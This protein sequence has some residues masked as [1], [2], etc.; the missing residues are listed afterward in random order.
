MSCLVLEGVDNLQFKDEQDENIVYDRD[1]KVQ[2]LVTGICGSDVHYWKKGS[3]GEFIV[4]SPLILGHESAGRVVEVGEHVKDVKIGDLVALEPSKPC[5]HCFDCKRGKYNLCPFMQFAATPPFHG[6]LRKYYVLP[7]DFCYKLPPELSVEEGALMEP[8]SVA[9]HMVKEASISFGHS[10]VIFGAGPIGLLCSAVARAYGASIVVVVDI[11]KE[12]LKFA[13]SYAAT[14]VHLCN[15]NR[16]PNETALEIIK[17][18][19]LGRGA[20]RAIEASGAATAIAT[21]I[22]LLRPGGTLVQA[23]MGKSEVPFPIVMTCVSYFVMLPLIEG[24][25]NCC[26]WII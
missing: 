14:G 15:V 26:S 8:L 16:A 7:S 5:R 11:R 23:G 18:F 19:S 13:L 6:T 12:R 1:V 9:V 20:D 25:G 2:V 3:I 21:A 17:K 4:I 10:V 24:K 22:H